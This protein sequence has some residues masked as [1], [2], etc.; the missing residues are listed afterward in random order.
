MHQIG[1]YIGSFI[2]MFLF[3][4]LWLWFARGRPCSAQGLMHISPVIRGT[5]EC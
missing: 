1:L 5:K 3:A 4:R 2:G